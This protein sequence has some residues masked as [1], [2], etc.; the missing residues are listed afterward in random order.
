[1]TKLI[2]SEKQLNLITKNL[3]R[4]QNGELIAYCDCVDGT[5]QFACADCEMCCVNNGGW[6]QG[7]SAPIVG[8]GDVSY[9]YDEG[10]IVTSNSSS[11]FG[12][13]PPN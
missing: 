10:P 12:Y 4:E 9:S 13:T 11:S 6:D 2:I 1:M 7:I 8:L 5:I 3:V